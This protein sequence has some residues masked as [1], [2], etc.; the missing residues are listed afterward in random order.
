MLDFKLN[1]RKEAFTTEALRTR[2]KHGGLNYFSV[3]P[4]CALCLCG[5]FSNL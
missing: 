2:S 5:E 3:I 4:L 1:V